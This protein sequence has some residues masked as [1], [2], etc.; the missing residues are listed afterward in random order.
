MMNEK[1]PTPLTIT[2][3]KKS[4][5][6]EIE[7]DNNENVMISFATLRAASKSA[8]MKHGKSL[9]SLDYR[10]VTILT[11]EPVGNY[12]IKPVF[13]DGHRTGIFNWRMLYDLGKKT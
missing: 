8:E 10:N 6:L 1:S 4:R 2:L 13:S 7:F 5:T 3:H 9:A 11:I 12:A